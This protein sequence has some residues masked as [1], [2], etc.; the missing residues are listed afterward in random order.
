[1][2]GFNFQIAFNRLSRQIRFRALSGFSKPV[3]KLG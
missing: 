3:L 1:L 2:P